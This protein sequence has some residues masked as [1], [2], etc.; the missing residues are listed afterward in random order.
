[1]APK[2]LSQGTVFLPNKHHSQVHT[3]HLHYY[4][5]ILQMGKP[6]HGGIHMITGGRVRVRLAL[7]LERPPCRERERGAGAKGKGSRTR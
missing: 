1:M 4:N 3:G 7:S 6:R 5:P 2:N